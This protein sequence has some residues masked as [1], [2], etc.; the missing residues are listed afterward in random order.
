MTDKYIL[1]GH[2]PVPEP[3][4][5]KWGRWMETAERH[6][7]FTN[8]DGVRVST[9]FLGL[10]HNFMEGGP[11]L[12]FETMIF[13]GPH[14]QYQTRCSTWAQAVIMHQRAVSKAMEDDNRLA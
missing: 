14:D 13:E 6:V 10:D 5:M 2:E 1:E 3:D 11:P 4:L 7:A 8:L 12:L 9:V